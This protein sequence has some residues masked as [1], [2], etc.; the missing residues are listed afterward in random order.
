MDELDVD[1]YYGAYTRS[2]TAGQSS[3]ELRVFGLGYID[4][5][6]QVLKTDNRPAPVRAADFGKIEIATWGADY[7]HVFNT[8]NSGKFHFLLWG[9]V[10]TG[11][12]GVLTQRAGAFVGEAGMAAAC[13][14]P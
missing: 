1:T 14:S 8:T 4:H 10:Q 9:A 13:R 3:G 7:V 2:V 6:T 12:W 5:R 11:S